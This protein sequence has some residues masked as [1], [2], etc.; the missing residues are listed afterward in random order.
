DPFGRARTSETAPRGRRAR[1]PP[2]LP[3]V[4]A[5]DAG[6]EIARAGRRRA[7]GDGWGVD[8]YPGRAAQA[9]RLRRGLLVLPR[10]GRSR[11]GAAV[12]HRGVGSRLIPELE[13][14]RGG[15]LRGTPRRLE[16]CG[17]P[18]PR[19]GRR[20]LGRGRPGRVGP[21]AVTERRVAELALD[22]GPHDRGIRPPQRPRRPDPGGG[23][24]PNRRL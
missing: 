16:G 1:H 21:A 24:R 7:A 12:G 3:G 22:R 8:D 15:A 4:P 20:G 19:D 9:P 23:G 5:R 17:G 18:L 14:V 2:R 10:A 6:L 13:P 11:P